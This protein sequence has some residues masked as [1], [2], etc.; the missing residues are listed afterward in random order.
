MQFAPLLPF[1]G[2]LLLPVGF[3]FVDPQHTA[4]FSNSGNFICG[5]F[6]KHR[7]YG[8]CERF[9]V[10]C[11]L[12]PTAIRFARAL[13]GGGATFLS[14]LGSHQFGAVDSTT[15]ISTYTLFFIDLVILKRGRDLRLDAAYLT[16]CGLFNQL[17]AVERHIKSS[18]NLVVP[19]FDCVA[20]EERLGEYE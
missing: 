4:R 11:P 2:H 7:F 6:P 13:E 3:F 12:A 15:L 17:W 8:L 19:V 20:V 16:T 9:L 18:V 10:D 1:V 14:T 5:N